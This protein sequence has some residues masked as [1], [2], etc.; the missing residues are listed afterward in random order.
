MVCAGDDVR[1]RVFLPQPFV[2]RYMG[3]GPD[4][5]GWVMGPE[6]YLAVGWI[7]LGQ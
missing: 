5:L 1:Q 2:V 4:G 3:V 7:W 6:V